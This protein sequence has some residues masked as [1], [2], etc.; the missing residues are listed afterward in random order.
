RLARL[1]IHRARHSNW[2]PCVLFC[3]SFAREYFADAVL[4]RSTDRVCRVFA[5]LH[6]LCDKARFFRENK[7]VISAAASRKNQIAVAIFEQQSKRAQCETLS[8]IALHLIMCIEIERRPS[9]LVVFV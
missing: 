1:W 3:G 2:F 8:N 6:P 7:D 4:N 9:R 5:Q